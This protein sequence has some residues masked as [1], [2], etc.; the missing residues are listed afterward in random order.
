MILK[1]VLFLDNQNPNRARIA[2]ALLSHATN[3]QVTTFSA[4]P[5]SLTLDDAATQALQEIGLDITS[6]PVGTSQSYVGQAL[7]LV[8]TL[9]DGGTET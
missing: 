6:V 9:C 7:D 8:V 5:G 3:Q 2:A 1:S 4:G